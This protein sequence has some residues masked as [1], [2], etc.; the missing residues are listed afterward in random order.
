MI[1]SIGRLSLKLELTDVWIDVPMDVQG[2][3]I[4]EKE[5]EHFTPQPSDVVGYK[6]QPEPVELARRPSGLRRRSGHD[7]RRA[8]VRLSGAIPEFRAFIECC[9]FLTSLPG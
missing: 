7:P 1:I 8:G 6:E 3:V 2:A 5:L 9:V 4:N